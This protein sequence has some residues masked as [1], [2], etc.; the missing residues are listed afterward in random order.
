MIWEHN[1]LFNKARFYVIKAESQKDGDAIRPLFYSFA[2]ELLCKASLSFIHPSL[3]ADPQ[4]EGQSLMY[5][6]GLPHRGQPKSLPAHS[7]FKRVQQ[8]IEPFLD[9]HLNFCE[10]FSSKRNEELHSGESPM[11]T[12]K[13]NEWLPKFYTVAN[14]L[15]LS[16]NKELKDLIGDDVAEHAMELITN[17]DKNEEDSIRKKIGNHKAVFMA[18]SDSQKN[19]LQ[20]ITKQYVLSN[21]TYNSKSV[22]CPACFSMALIYGRE[23]QQKEPMYDGEEFY[24]E[25]IYQ[26]NHLICKACGLELKNQ[27]E[28]LVA[29]I[30]IRFAK[31]EGLDLHDFYHSE[32]YPEYDNM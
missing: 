17:T 5:S 11:S 26:T 32:Q 23:V 8:L 27:R 1:I 6:L 25:V 20:K 16:M 14:I 19:D 9:S 30:E 31:V 4:D 24:T 12:M 2:I 18:K 13:D 28:I 7:I 10:Y 15:C 3:I 22:D 21:E 29:N